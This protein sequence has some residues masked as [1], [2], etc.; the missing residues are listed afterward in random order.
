MEESYM[1]LVDAGHANRSDLTYDCRRF[2]L[3]RI[4]GV[5]LAAACAF[6]TG[7]ALVNAVHAQQATKKYEN[8]KPSSEEEAKQAKNDRFEVSAS[9]GSKL[10]VKLLE[11]KIPLK[12]EFGTLMIPIG[13][14]RQIDFANRVPD[15]LAA[16]ISDTVNRLGD[17]DYQK[18]EEATNEL[19]TLGAVAYPALLEASQSE[20]PEVARRAELLL[21]QIR[22][23]VSTEILQFRDDDM[24]YT[25]KS[26]VAGM[27]ELDALR[28]ENALFGEQKLK[29]VMLRRLSTGGDLATTPG[30]VLPDPGSLTKYRAQVGKT[31]YFRIT[32]PQPG[33]QQGSVWGTNI[34]TFDSHLASAAVHAGAVSPGQT[35]VIGVTI[36]AGQGAFQ[37]SSRNGITSENWGEYPASYTFVALGNIQQVPVAVPAQPMRRVIVPAQR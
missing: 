22:G 23:I 13:D 10:K 9:D 1:T 31:M 4:A 20:D 36:L 26:H 35:R 18:R 33:A 30:E 15:D 27:I 7:M 17:D 11:E 32:G 14:I 12:T 19:L 37:G 8:P 16:R 3:I 24:I 34:Y 6:S 28:V 29:L 5:T 2:R 25:D 21:E